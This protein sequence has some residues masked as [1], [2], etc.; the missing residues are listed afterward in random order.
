MTSKRIYVVPIE[1]YDRFLLDSLRLYLS[2]AFRL[3]AAIENKPININRVFDPLRNQYNSSQL[4]SQL[5][6][7]PDKMKEIAENSITYFNKY[8]S[9][10]TV[11]NYY[12]NMLGLY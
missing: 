6:N 2:N 12:K 3:P 9:L 4:L 8:H 11:G 7:N 10:E 1:F 5:I